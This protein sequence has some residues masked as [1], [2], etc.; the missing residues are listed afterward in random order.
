MGPGHSILFPF[1]AAG[2]S[3]SGTL[4]RLF[5]GVLDILPQLRVPAELLLGLAVYPH[6]AEAGSLLLTALFPG[7]R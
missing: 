1:R 2:L 3:T 5:L 6:P 4:T 7:V